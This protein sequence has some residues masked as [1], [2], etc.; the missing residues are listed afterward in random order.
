[1]CHCHIQKWLIN[2]YLSKVFCITI[3]L[4]EQTEMGVFV[5]VNTTA[6]L[7]TFQLRVTSSGQRRIQES[8]FSQSFSCSPRPDIFSIS[9]WAPSVHLALGRPLLATREVSSAI[10]PPAMS[11]PFMTPL[12]AIAKPP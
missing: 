1:M 7:W 5:L 6:I 10:Y 2:F 3:Q 11:I 8:L 9:S 4:H 12:V